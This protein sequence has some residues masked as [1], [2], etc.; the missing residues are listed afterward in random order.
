MAKPRQAGN[1]QSQLEQGGKLGIGIELTGEEADRT[2]SFQ[3]IFGGAETVEARAGA[4]AGERARLTSEAP[5]REE[6]RIQVL[7]TGS[8]RAR[9]SES[10]EQQLP[11][12]RGELQ[13]P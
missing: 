7:W 11:S 9:D 4:G 8:E 6:E 2:G 1:I 13:K 12:A 10:S 5:R 3:N